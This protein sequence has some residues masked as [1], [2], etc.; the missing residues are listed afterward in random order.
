MRV[1]LDEGPQ[2]NNHVRARRTIAPPSLK[3]HSR[4]EYATPVAALRAKMSEHRLAR[5]ECR[6]PEHWSF[7]GV[8]LAHGH[9]EWHASPCSGCCRS[10]ACR[11]HLL[12]GRPTP[13]RCAARPP[14][15]F[16]TCEAARR[17]YSRDGGPPRRD[18]PLNAAASAL[19]DAAA[20]GLYAGKRHYAPSNSVRRR[21][22]SSRSA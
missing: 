15:A 4:R 3:P 19:D 5:Q 16:P 11:P 12:E 6:W 9:W 7:G 17:R 22:W 20:R 2:F 13:E 14:C 21:S 1:R 10:K 18:L 8:L